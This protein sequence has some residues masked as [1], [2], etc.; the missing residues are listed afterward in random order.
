ME[1]QL[2]EDFVKD[3]GFTSEQVQAITGH[4]TTNFIP[5][6]QKQWDGKANENAE[7]IIN[8]AIKSTQKSFGVELPREQGEKYSDYLTRLSSHIVG[9]KQSQVEQKLKD[10]D[11]KMKEFKGNETLSKEY[12]TLKKEK[13]TLLEK[14]SNYDELAEKANKADEYEQS[15]SKLTL[16]VAFN[17][18]KPNFPK[19]VNIYEA[20]A[21]W[22]EFKRT[23]LDKH[24]IELVDNVPMAVDKENHFK[25]VKLEDLVSKDETLSKLMEGRQQSGI[26][27]QPVDFRAI[28]GVPFKVPKDADSKTISETI[29]KHLSDNGIGS[30]HPDFEP[31]FKEYHNKIR[32]G[33]TLSA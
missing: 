19:E 8:G 1:F 20:R 6:F 23:V 25:S 2:S 28:D 5:E 13:E 29:K 4:V 22:D 12:E 21:K 15:L 30:L 32:E 10:L 16:E 7:G 33:Q 11:T 24:T 9:E 26:G 14:Y 3:N 18:V 27:G 17:S 31:R